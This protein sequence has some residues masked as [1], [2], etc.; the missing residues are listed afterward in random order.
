MKILVNSYQKGA[1]GERAV[2]DLFRE[3]GFEEAYRTN[4]FQGN[5]TDG[6]SDVSNTPYLHVECKW[7]ER[8]NIDDAMIQATEDAQLQDRD[9]IP[10]VFHKKKHKKVLVTMLADDWFEFYKAYVAI[11]EKGDNKVE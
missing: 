4:Q 1:R 8:L 2:R 6:S 3:N 5:H 9:E 11:N 7:V 10:V